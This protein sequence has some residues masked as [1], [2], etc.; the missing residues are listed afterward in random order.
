M[1]STRSSSTL[2]RPNRVVSISIVE[3]HFLDR[4]PETGPVE[5]RAIQCRVLHRV[6]AHP[7]PHA[8]F[9]RPDAYRSSDAGWPAWPA[10]RPAGRFHRPAIPPRRDSAR[11]RGACFCAVS[12][13]TPTTDQTG[14]AVRPQTS[15][16]LCT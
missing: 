1:F 8:G 11:S 10:E 14:P 2:I 12:A 9:L 5:T 7:A 6:L 13:A 4:G 3:L 15:W 16:R